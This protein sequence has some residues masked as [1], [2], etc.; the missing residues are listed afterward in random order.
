MFRYDESDPRIFIVYFGA[1]HDEPEPYRDMIQRWVARLTNEN[2]QRFGV[3]A[4]SEPHV[5]DEHDEESAREHEA[6]ITRI[7]NDFRRDYRHL[8]AQINTAYARVFPPEVIE[9]YYPTE[10]L[11]E[12]AQQG[13]DR[14]A[15]YN[16]G[17]P[18]R[19][20]VDVELA[21]AWLVEQMD[22]E[23][24]FVEHEVEPSVPAGK[25]GL[26]YGSSTGVTEYVAEAIQDEWARSGVQPVEMVNIGRVKDASQLLAYDHLI[27]GIPTWNI[28]QLQDDWEI[29]F[30]QL[31][32]LDFTGK[33]VA[34]FGIGDQYNYADNFQDA[35]GILGLKL[36]ERG[37]EL[38]G[39]WPTEGYEFSE[40]LALE[41]GRFMGLAIDDVN[42][43]ALTSG[44]VRQWVAQI[45]GEFSLQSVQ[46]T[47][48]A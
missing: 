34:M 13:L 36:R 9:Q 2:S 29:L 45:I 11:I 10:E 46:Q 3:M 19:G 1:D 35:V 38:V 15:Q 39:Y 27:L 43:R 17:I 26:F 28:G 8:T 6:E 32:K 5:H 18:G 41:D 31:D 47:A 42:Q 25:V 22:R 24:V 12:Q 4:V 44:R 16:W 30:P 21:K 7:F 48:S 37:A 33:Q 14:Y 20:F 40:S 23:P